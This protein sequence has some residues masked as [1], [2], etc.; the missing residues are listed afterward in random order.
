MSLCVES[1]AHI[2]GRFLGVVEVCRFY[3]AD[4][5]EYFI[6]LQWHRKSLEHKWHLS[7]SL[8]KIHS[9]GAQEWKINWINKT[10]SEK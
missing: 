6:N 10:G 2:C 7:G 8:N 3:P 4:T 1:S 5:V 9:Y